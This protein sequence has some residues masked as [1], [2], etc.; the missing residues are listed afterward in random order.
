MISSDSSDSPEDVHEEGLGPDA[1][2]AR[3]QAQM[4]A[5]HEARF[6]REVVERFAHPRFLGELPLPDGVGEARRGGRSMSVQLALA[7]QGGDAG[8]I[9]AA[10]FW[11]NG[12]GPYMAAG[13]AACELA[14]GRTPAEA[15]ALSA[16]E[17]IAVL[18]GLAREK[19][20]YAEAAAGAVRA[21]AE[22]IL[23]RAGQGVAKAGADPASCRPPKKLLA[24]FERCAWTAKTLGSL[25]EREDEILYIW[26]EEEAGMAELFFGPAGARTLTER[27]PSV[28]RSLYLGPDAKGAWALA[29]REVEHAGYDVRRVAEESTIVF[30]GEKV[31]AYL[32]RILGNDDGEA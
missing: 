21:A 32:K 16:D 19:R 13:D 7:G 26:R 10:R 31:G 8:R 6:G 5:A 14:L 2:A 23:A 22:A 9:A 11:T 3:L 1:L 24:L 17:V 18:P 30:D 25:P 20:E 15:A 29:V 28:R 4:D 12:C 27:H